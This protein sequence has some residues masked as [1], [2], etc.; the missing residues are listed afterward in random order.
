M[1]NSDVIEI[2][3]SRRMLKKRAGNGGKA[4][5]LKLPAWRRRQIGR[6]GARKRWRKERMRKVNGGS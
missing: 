2:K 5:A 4:R 6:I 1:S 3:I